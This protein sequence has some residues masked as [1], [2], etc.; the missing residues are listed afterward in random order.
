MSGFKAFLL[1]GNLIDV[2]VG[3]VIGVAFTTVINGLVKD[4]F[5]PLLAAL[6]A[7]R[8]RNLID[9][10]ERVVVFDTGAGFKSEAPVDLPMPSP[11]ANDPDEWESVV[12][13][14]MARPLATQARR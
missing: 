11:V 3:I 1:R 8:D 6:P 5:T 10:G 14:R 4:L 7:L 2:A 13:S 9:A 12:E